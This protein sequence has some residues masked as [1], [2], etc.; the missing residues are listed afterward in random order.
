VVGQGLVIR[1][2]H[3]DALERADVDAELA[4]RAQVLDDLGFGN[5]LRLDPRDQLAML[6]L[7]GVHRT[8]D[9]ADRAVDAALRVDVILPLR[10]TPDRVRRALDLADR[11]SDAFVS[12]EVGHFG[13]AVYMNGQ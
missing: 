6:V 4:P 2:D 9:A 7:D 8:V 11:A 5:V 13:L 1:V 3:A 10:L 12:D